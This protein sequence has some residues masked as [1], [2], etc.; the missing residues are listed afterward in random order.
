MSKQLERLAEFEKEK[1]ERE[2][3]FYQQAQQNVN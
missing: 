3:R 2:A 1:E